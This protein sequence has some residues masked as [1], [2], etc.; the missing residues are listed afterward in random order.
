MRQ[1]PG[2]SRG[3]SCVPRDDSVIVAAELKTGSQE[4]GEPIQLLRWIRQL[5]SQVPDQGVGI[6]ARQQQGGSRALHHVP[7]GGVTEAG[8]A[9]GMGLETSALVPP[10]SSMQSLG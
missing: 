8:G 10:C 5:L 4:R 2:G 3:A 6:S 7:G 1:H 9:G